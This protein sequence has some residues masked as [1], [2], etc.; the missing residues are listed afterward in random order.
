[1]SNIYYPSGSDLKVYG[2][3]EVTGSLSVSGSGTLINIGE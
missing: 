1:M 3:V 2:G